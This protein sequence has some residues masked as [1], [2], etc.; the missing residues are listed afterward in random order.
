MIKPDY[1][2][3]IPKELGTIHFI[4]IGGSGMSGIARLVIGMGHKV[5]GSDVRESPNIG[6]LRA[7]GAEI[8]IGHD[9]SK[10]GAPDTVV[11]TSALWP[12]NP[13]LVE[14]QSRGLPILH[15][16]A[17]LAHLASLSTDVFRTRGSECAHEVDCFWK[18]AKRS[19]NGASQS[20]SRKA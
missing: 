9:S 15:R 13:E 2:Q 19:A 3:P 1:S 12:H 20:K 8:H 6:Q 17:L 16:S 5:T 4:G 14:A 11:V 10:L 18:L 7:L